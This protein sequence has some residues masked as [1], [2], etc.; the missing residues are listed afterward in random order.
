MMIQAYKL[1]LNDKLHSIGI[2]DGKKN[3]NGTNALDCWLDEPT[4]NRYQ[5]INK[6]VKTM[7]NRLSKL[8]K[9][10]KKFNLTDE[11]INE[12]IKEV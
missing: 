7:E 2:M 4:K 6:E 1:Y 10:V 12:Y 3:Y 8:E 5:E 11:Q 9:L